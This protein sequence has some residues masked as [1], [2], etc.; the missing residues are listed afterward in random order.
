MRRTQIL[1]ITFCSLACLGYANT[2]ANAGWFGPSNYEE[3]VLEKM[4]GQQ[5]YMLKTAQDACQAKFKDESKEVLLDQRL[6]QANWCLDEQTKKEICI[7]DKPNN[8]EITSVKLFYSYQTNC[9]ERTAYPPDY[10]QWDF[11]TQDLWL[12]RQDAKYPL[13]TVAGEK[14]YFSATYTF[15]MPQRNYFCVDVA[16]Y[17][18][19]K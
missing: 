19:I 8:Y 4:K 2:S 5:G 13:V 3:C 12:L 17:G 11:S 10:G 6:I 18:F 7:V 15:K 14:S 9:A 16:F 1:A